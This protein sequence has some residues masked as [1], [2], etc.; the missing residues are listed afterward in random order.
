MSLRASKQIAIMLALV[1]ASMQGLALL[2]GAS[3]KFAP[4]VHGPKLVVSFGLD[5]PVLGHGADGEPGSARNCDL[6]LYLDGHS[7]PTD[8]PGAVYPVYF[9]VSGTAFVRSDVFVERFF[10]SISLR[11]PPTSSL[12]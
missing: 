5:D 1:L 6:L 12:V 10:S 4:H 2:H 11:G 3:F 8:A 9:A 7:R